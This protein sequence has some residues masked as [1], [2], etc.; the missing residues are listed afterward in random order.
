MDALQGLGRWLVAGCI[1]AGLMLAL[2]LVYGLVAERGGH[3]EQ[4]VQRVAASHA[5]PQRLTG[6]LRVVPWSERRDVAAADGNSAT[7]ERRGYLLQLPAS[8]AVSGE[9]LPQRRRSGVFTV[10]VYRWQGQLQARFEDWQL[11]LHAGRVYGQPYLVLGMDDVRGLAG[12]PQLRIDGRAGPMQPGSRELAPASA[13]VHALLPPARGDRLAASTVSIGLV[14][15]GT[16]SLAVVPVGEDNRIELWSRWP[17][18]SFD[19]QFLTAEPPRVDAAGFRARWTIP[20]LATTVGARLRP[21]LE[22]GSLDGLEQVRVSLVEPVD[23]YVQASR[24]TKY[25]FL[26]VLLTLIVFGVYDLV[27][28]LRLHPLQYLLVGL[29]LVIFFLL[30]LSL[31]EHLPFGVA[32]LAASAACIALQAWYLAGVLRSR[33]QALGFAAMLGALYAVLYALLASQNLALLMGSGLLFVVLAA[34][35]RLTRSLQLQAPGDG[36]G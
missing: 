19:G 18:P 15:A 21:A 16:R 12:Q 6:P 28:R 2:G 32:Y 35:M 8:Y 13:G 29:V 7:D 23:V 30:L 24:A 5:G 17:H 34:V 14:L 10:P 4:A 11:P 9:L 1:L 36:H 26:F 31:A 27:R 22:R 20:A 25:G 3:R 33:R